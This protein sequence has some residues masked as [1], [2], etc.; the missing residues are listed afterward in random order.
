MFY[1]S[2][3]NKISYDSTQYAR[4]SPSHPRF[5]HIFRSIPSELSGTSTDLTQSQPRIGFSAVGIWISIVNDYDA[6]GIFLQGYNSTP[7]TII[8]PIA[9]FSWLISIVLA[10]KEVWPPEERYRPKFATYGEPIVHR[11]SPHEVT[12]MDGRIDSVSHNIL[13]TRWDPRYPVLF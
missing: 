10:G 1:I 3:S 7:S 8:G 9:A 6:K 4:P 5:P 11:N 13:T 12:N 2:L